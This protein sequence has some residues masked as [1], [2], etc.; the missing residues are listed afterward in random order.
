MKL[1]T[2][3]NRKYWYIFSDNE[4]NSPATAQ[5]KHQLA[6]ICFD[7]IC[8]DQR[9]KNEAQSCWD[10]IMTDLAESI[11]YSWNMGLLWRLR[12]WLESMGVGRIRVNNSSSYNDLHQ[13]GNARDI[14]TFPLHT[15]IS[16]HP[17]CK[18][19]LALYSKKSPNICPVLNFCCAFCRSFFLSA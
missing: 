9:Q 1:K 10:I 14:S 15:P 2:D 6:P 16:I 4:F 12:L 5:G 11:G 13:G 18:F 7:W 3:I 19:I 17:L 8:S